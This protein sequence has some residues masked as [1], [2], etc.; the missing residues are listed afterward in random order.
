V[1]VLV[2]GSSGHLGEALVISLRSAG[3]ETVGLDLKD[4]EFT[5]IVGA[6]SDR[7]IVASAIRGV[8]SVIHTATLHKPHIVTHSKQDFID[9]NITGTLVLL[10][11]AAQ[12]GTASFV[13]TSSTS[14]FGHS[15]RP[16]DCGP[17]V[18]VSEDLQAMPRNIYGITKV[19]AEN[20]CELFHRSR[21]LNC[22]VLRTS[23]FFPDEDDDVGVRNRYRDANVKANEFL[24]RRVDLHDVVSAHVSAMERAASIGF[25][26]VIVSATTPF[27]RGDTFELRTD[28]PSVVRKYFAQQPEIYRKLGWKMVPSITRI[29]DN[30]RARQLLDWHP[31]YD[32]Q[33]V[34]SNVAIGSDPRSDIAR[35]VGTKRYHSELFEHGPYPVE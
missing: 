30:S 1:K 26:R 34:L 10:E 8:D 22:I 16:A 19:A 6:I 35:A 4:S 12:A 3:V 11:H 17:A 14:V 7:T 33:H 15:L 31:K 5:D 27:T 28:A 2:T 24:F 9:T 32:Y 25:D 23:R 29:Y 20:L 18:W 21:G 13:F